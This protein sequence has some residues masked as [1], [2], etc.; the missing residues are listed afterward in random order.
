M[1]D[2]KIEINESFPVHFIFK[3]N[4]I[5]MFYLT[6]Q[7]SVIV[8]GAKIGIFVKMPTS[9]IA[10]IQ[11][12]GLF[13]FMDIATAHPASG[14]RERGHNLSN[15]SLIIIINYFL[16]IVDIAISISQNIAIFIQNSNI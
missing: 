14:A 10:P 3:V 11:K 9:A 8:N 2:F 12:S 5:M 15:F 4:A 1:A 13:T 16:N 7:R 6:N